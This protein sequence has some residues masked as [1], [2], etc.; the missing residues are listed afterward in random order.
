MGEARP[1]VDRQAGPH[2][3]KCGPTHWAVFIPLLAILIATGAAEAQDATFATHLVD[4][5]QGSTLTDTATALGDGGYE[6]SD[7]TW[8][9]LGGWYHTDWPD[10]HIEF[11]SQFGEDFGL[12]WGLSTGERAE[13]YTIDPSIRLG[14]VAQAHPSPD[15]V[16]SLSVKTILAGQLNEHACEGDYGEIGGIQKVNCRLAAS[17]L[18]PEETLQ[19]LVSAIPSRLY[20]SLSY[21]ASF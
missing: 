11:M 10:T 21:R 12:L 7:G 15:A 17:F 20:V 13:K 6:L 9:S 16:L 8:Q 14:F 1:R 2:A 18:P 19:Y 4:I 3:F 5:G